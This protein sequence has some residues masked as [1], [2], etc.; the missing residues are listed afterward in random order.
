M[1]DFQYYRLWW[2]LL[3]VPGYLVIMYFKWMKGFPFFTSLYDFLSFS[4]W[5]TGFIG[6]VCYVVGARIY[7]QGFWRIIFFLDFGDTAATTIYD[8]VTKHQ[9]Y[10]TPERI[11]TLFFFLLLTHIYYFSLWLYA[12]ESQ[13]IWEKKA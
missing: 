13:G 10:F 11:K 1:T 2:L 12:F 7:R 9:D 6:A 8:F 5:H 3:L 4:L